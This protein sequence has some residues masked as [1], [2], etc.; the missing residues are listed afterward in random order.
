MVTKFDMVCPGI[1]LREGVN[2]NNITT[3]DQRP[4]FIFY[5]IRG[6]SEGRCCTLSL[7]ELLFVIDQEENNDIIA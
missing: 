2:S 7:Y 4:T 1:S 6:I 3:N 5:S